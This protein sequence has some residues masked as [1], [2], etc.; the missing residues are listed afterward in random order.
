MCALRRPSVA[1][2]I[3]TTEGKPVT[4]V[5]LVKE[6]MTIGRKAYNDIVLEDRAVSGQHATISLMLDDAMLEDMGST[7]GT[8]VAGNKVYRQKLTDGDII[9]IA[10]F[11]ITFV[12]SPRKAQPSGR[13]EVM[14]GAHTGKSLALNKPLTT[15]GKPGEVVVAITYAGG[16]YSAAKIDGETGP[17]INGTF[18]DDDPRRLSHGDMLDLTGT[19]MTF[20]AK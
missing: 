2:I 6:R 4:E 1:K 14:S 8:F 13:I 9:N 11:S 19:R 10:H 16:T 20:L 15:I 18:L 7:N 17:I 12:A 5:E 3:I